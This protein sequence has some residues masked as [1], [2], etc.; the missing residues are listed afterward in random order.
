[1][2][3]WTFGTSLIISLGV[4]LRISSPRTFNRFLRLLAFDQLGY[5]RFSYTTFVVTYIGVFATTLLTLVFLHQEVCHGQNSEDSTPYIYK[6]F[7]TEPLPADKISLLFANG[8]VR[9]RRTILQNT[10]NA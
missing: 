10:D 2:M 3:V 5:V 1:M 7:K 8:Q 4:H 9:K 6:F